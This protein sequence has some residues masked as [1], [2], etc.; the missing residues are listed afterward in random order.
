MTS[1]KSKTSGFAVNVLHMLVTQGLARGVHIATGIV[2]ARFL[3]PHDRGL[4]SLL[5]MIPQTLEVLLKLGIAP[6]NVYMICREKMNLGHVVSNSVLLA[7]GLGAVALLILPFGGALGEGI[8]PNVDGWYLTVAVVIVPFYI[9]STYLTS[10]LHALNRFAI[11]NRQAVIGAV[12]R[13]ALTFV[14]LVLL[15]HGLPAAFL[16]HVVIGVLASVWLLVAVRSLASPAF[17][18]DL[19][20][21]AATVKFGLKSHA[22]TLLTALH[23]RLDHFVIAWFLGPSE[24]AFYAIATHIA[25]LISGIHRPASIVLYPRLASGEATRVHDMTITVC[26]HVLFLESLAGIALVLGSKFMIGL[27]YGPAYLPAV[28]PLL[29]V[30]PGIL[31]LS[32]FNLLVRNFM[33]RNKQRITIVAGIVGLV[34]NTVLTIVLVPRLGIN[35]AALAS[36]ASYTLTTSILLV[37]FRRDSGISLWEFVRVRQS[38][39][40][41]YTK[42]LARYVA[43]PVTA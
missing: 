17:R 25:E 39:L 26:R 32:L 6:A 31:M 12:A 11:A 14:A 40:E 2:T 5:L 33:S 42:L 15:G 20:V 24:V 19:G 34:A 35:G 22:H 38:D 36:T 27:L 13:L 18:P 37:A 21:A 30:L 43:R 1:P 28:G 7:F 29:I 16:V 23:L 4:Y 41:F 8:L 10:I 9:L 3:G